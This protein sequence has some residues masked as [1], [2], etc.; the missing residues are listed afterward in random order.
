MK[1]FKL[2]TL[3]ILLAFATI[4]SAQIKKVNVSKSTIA[5]VGKKVTGSKH[6]GNINFKEGNLI[7]KSKKLV[8]GNFTVDMNSINV[9]DIKAGEGKEKLEGHLKN[10]DFFGTETHPTATLVF[11][12]L[13]DKGNGTYSVTADLTIKGITESVKFEIVVSKNTAKANLKVDRTKFGIKYGSG[14]FFDSLGD[15]A[16]NDEFDLNITLNF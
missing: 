16:I 14:S 15:K 10:D 9:T 4:A 11:K 2:F 6:E 3:S 13:G 7:F 12:S 8:G 5:W 1:N